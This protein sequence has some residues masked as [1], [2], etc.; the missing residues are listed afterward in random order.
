MSNSWLT[1]FDYKLIGHKLDWWLLQTH[2]P[3]VGFDDCYKF[4]GHKLDLMTSQATKL[5]GHKL[6]GWLTLHWPQVDGW[7]QTNCQQV[8]GLGWLQYWLMMTWPQN[9][10]TI[11]RLQNDDWPYGNYTGL[12]ELQ[13]WVIAMSW[14][15]NGITYPT[16][17]NDPKLTAKNYVGVTRLA[18]ASYDLTTNTKM[19]SFLTYQMNQNNFFWLRLLPYNLIWGQVDCK[20]DWGL[21]FG[22]WLQVGLETNIYDYNKLVLLVDLRPQADKNLIDYKLVDLDRL[23]WLE[24]TSWLQKFDWLDY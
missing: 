23:D 1:L 8:E 7:L 21:G 6:V 15:Q 10:L 11:Q 5:I 20:Y 3:Q 4:I 24:L 2:W 12:N 16:A 17:T 14:L 22:G 18:L 13:V 19:T 9:W